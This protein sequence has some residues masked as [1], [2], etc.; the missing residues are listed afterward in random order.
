MGMGMGGLWTNHVLIQ[1]AM[2]SGATS[3]AVKM[4]CLFQHEWSWITKPFSEPPCSKSRIQH[5]GKKL[6]ARE[7]NGVLINQGQLL[8]QSDQEDAF[9]FPWP[10][11]HR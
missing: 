10:L 6:T 8:Q 3:L 9:S 2:Y 5:Y 1:Y 11:K 4:C 7:K